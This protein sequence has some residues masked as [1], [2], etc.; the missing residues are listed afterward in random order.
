MRNSVIIGAGTQ[1]QVLCTY[2]KEA[3]V[4]VIG[5]IDD[6]IK[7]VGE[8][9]LGLP[10]IGTY[11]DLFTHKFKSMIDDVFCPIGANRIRVTYLSSLKEFGY[12]ITSYI[13][14]SVIISPE[15]KLG[16]AIYM[17]PGNIVMPHTEIGSYF[18]VNTC[19]TI[20]HHTTIHDG[21]FISSG[22]NIG[23]LINVKKYAYIG[24]GVTA[25]TGIKTIGRDCLIGAGTVVIKDVP[26]RAVIVGNPGR[27]LRYK[28]ELKTKT[29]Y[30]PEEQY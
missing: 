30:N 2:L 13:H 27:I 3:N 1:G 28:E 22:V 9:V 23:A 11:R 26:D 17:F 12:G 24:M 5:F 8:R 20:A 16:E 19:S 4:N 29:A 25:M 14:P 10:V 6:N 7:L 15:V 21:V 18:M